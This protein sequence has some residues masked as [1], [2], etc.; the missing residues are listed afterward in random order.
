MGTWSDTV[1]ESGV[2][3]EQMKGEREEF[4]KARS[5]TNGLEIE[6]KGKQV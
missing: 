1:E 4:A 3:K 6:S 5:R 2:S